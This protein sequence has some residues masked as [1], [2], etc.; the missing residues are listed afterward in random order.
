M[1]RRAFQRVREAASRDFTETGLKALIVGVA[2]F[3]IVVA[4]SIN[5]KWVLAGILAYLI[6]P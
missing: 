2:L 1:F 5:N 3:W 6:L 4:L